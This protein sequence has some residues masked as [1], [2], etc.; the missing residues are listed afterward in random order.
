V[1]RRIS[2]YVE[3]C[4]DP[5]ANPES[6]RASPKFG[7]LFNTLV[8]SCVPGFELEE[9]DLQKMK[10]VWPAGE[11]VAEEVYLNFCSLIL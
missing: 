11:K 4:P 7:P 5:Q 3:N 9:H 6:I 2:Y 1:N 8:P 10:E